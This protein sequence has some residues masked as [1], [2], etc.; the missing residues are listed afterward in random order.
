MHGEWAIYGA[1]RCDPS[2]VQQRVPIHQSSTGVSWQFPSIFQ[3]RFWATKGDVD[4]AN[5]RRLGVSNSMWLAFSNGYGFPR[6]PPRAADPQLSWLL[7]I[8]LPALFFGAICA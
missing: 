3:T 2:G 1:R 6:N 4:I 7:A 8:P 5:L